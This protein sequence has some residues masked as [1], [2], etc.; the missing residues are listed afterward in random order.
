MTRGPITNQ[1]IDQI[2]SCEGY[3]ND[4]RETLRG[5][6]FEIEEAPPRMR[7][8]SNAYSE[9]IRTTL[10][11]ASLKLAESINANNAL[12]RHLRGNRP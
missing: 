12:L 10:Q 11:A 2:A 7:L 6:G 3:E 1:E 8:G 9:I 5:M 4:L